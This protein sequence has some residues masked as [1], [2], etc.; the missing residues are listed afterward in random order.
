M[1]RGPIRILVAAAALAAAA[2]AQHGG[3]SQSHVYFPGTEILGPEEMRIVVVGSGSPQVRRSQVAACF[4]VEL[5]SGDEFLFDLGAGSILNLAALDIPYDRLDKVFITHLHTDHWGD[6][7]SYLVSSWVNG[8]TVPLKVWGPSGAKPEHGTKYAV[9]RAL[10]ALTWDLTSR[11]GELPRGGDRVEVTEFDYRE[12]R[13]V[14]EANGVVIRAWPAVHVLDGA[15]SYS[16]EWKGMKF[17]YSGDTAPNRWYVEEAKGADV[18]V[19]ETFFTVRQLIEG[20]HFHPKVAMTVG[21]EFHTA[22]EAAGRIFSLVKPRLAV[23]YH[24]FNEFDTHDELVAAVRKYYDGPLVFADDF[25]VFNVTKDA[26]R[27]RR[28]V[29]AREVW[30][31]PVEGHPEKADPA[32]KARLSDHIAAGKLD[33]DDVLERIVGD[34]PEEYRRQLVGDAPAPERSQLAQVLSAAFREVSGEGTFY[35]DAYERFLGIR[36]DPPAAVAADP[37]IPREAIRAD[38]PLGK[39]FA[40]GA[41]S[42]GAWRHEPYLFTGPDGRDTGFEHVLADAMVERVRA[43]YGLDRL[44][45]RWVAVDVSLPGGGQDNLV[46]FDALLGPLQR[47]DYD[48][49]FSGL[50]D[51]GR[52]EVEVVCPTMEFFWTAVWTGAG[53]LDVSALVGADR[54]AFLR[55]LVEHPGLTVLSTPGGPSEETV[56][57]IVREVAEA[58]GSVTGRTATVAE[59]GEA[60]A[61]QT[62]HFVVGDGVALSGFARRP[63]FR[64]RNLGLNVRPDLTYALAPVVAKGR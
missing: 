1:I 61:R 24:A 48:V 21:T 54:A 40:A 43:H 41:V 39:A 59:L 27:Q 6:F 53:G 12:P 7:S 46:L 36:R 2:S 26:I 25:L 5:G 29:E 28:A 44:E 49:A 15:V 55:F 51:L 10:E 8:R 22:P 52:P 19:H 32:D 17:A 3:S 64:G 42:F 60:M 4:L 14:Y 50:I 35:A 13:V 9:D 23:A 58:G 18:A 37:W 16:L 38:G 62:A 20:S 34:L 63:G 30:A 45:A 33:I 47:G 31:P 11:R 57:G 56:Q